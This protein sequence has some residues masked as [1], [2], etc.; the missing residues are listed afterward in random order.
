MTDQ[1]IDK[2][3][4]R[5][6]LDAARQEYSNLLEE[7]PEHDFSPAFEKKM[8]KLLRRAEHPAWHR[9]V[10]AVACL[11]LV[12]LL[13]GCAVLAV[14]PAAREAVTSWVR[15]FYSNT[16][17]YHFAGPENPSSEA[18]SYRPTW[19]PDGYELFD[20][21]SDTAKSSIEYFNADDD[22]IALVCWTGVESITM[23]VVM[24]EGDVEKQV[25]ISDSPADLYLSQEGVAE[26]LIW[27]D[28]E[29]NLVFQLR[30]ALSEEEIIKVAE[31]IQPVPS[32]Q[33]PHRP[34]WIPTGYKHYHTSKGWKDLDLRYANEVDE[35]IRFC[36]WD[37]DWGAQVQAEM[38]EAVYAL[39]SE[40]VEINGFPAE[41]YMGVD[42]INHLFWPVEDVDGAYW[43]T[44]PLTGAEL[45][46]I[47][48]SI[49]GTN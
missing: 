41:L 18:L 19:V 11:L 16:F 28:E 38:E 43:I 26:L 12:L 27:I 29:R 24:E 36:Y 30:G 4:H 20:E 33:A 40:T 3:A 17:I 35:Q 9:F 2:L 10:R 34:A 8:E 49:G 45:V 46:K 47:A 23:H 31:S 37:S 42:G 7:Q 44:G 32:R 39:E 25:F 5:V 13:T 1:A 22:T 14:S 48:E 15:E 6:L 21:N